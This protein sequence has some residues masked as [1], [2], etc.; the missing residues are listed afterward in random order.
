MNQNGISYSWKLRFLETNEKKR[1]TLR[2][3]DFAGAQTAGA[4]I[5]FLRTARNLYG[6]M[7]YVGVPDPVG[8][9]M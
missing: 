2:T 5:H 7:M 6:H 3:L 1:S 4:D 9:S 8:S